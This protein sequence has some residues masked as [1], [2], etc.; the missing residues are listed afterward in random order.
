MQRA[1]TLA[2]PPD[3]DGFANLFDRCIQKG[4]S[5]IGIV[6]DTRQRQ[7]TDHCRENAHGLATGLLAIG[8]GDQATEHLDVRFDP[9]F[10]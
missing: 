10:E 9:S 1:P 6:Y 8:L 5:E 7:R 4:L 2:I 3:G